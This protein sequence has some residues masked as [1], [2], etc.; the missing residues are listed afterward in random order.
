MCGL[1]NLK[2]LTWDGGL[3]CKGA[4][5]FPLQSHALVQLPYF[6]QAV[7]PKIKI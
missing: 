2:S 5:F 1:L 6:P 7:G 3:Y 4:N